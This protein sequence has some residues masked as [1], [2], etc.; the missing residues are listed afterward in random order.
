[1]IDLQLLSEKEKA[2]IETL[3]HH[4][5]ESKDAHYIFSIDNILKK[6]FSLN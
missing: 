3:C 6:E 5:L 2:E 1:M 4:Y